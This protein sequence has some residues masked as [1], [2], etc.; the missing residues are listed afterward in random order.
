MAASQMP[1]LLAVRNAIERVIKG[2]QQVSQQPTFTE[3]SDQGVL[4]RGQHADAETLF[5]LSRVELHVVC[6]NAVVYNQNKVVVDKA[7]MSCAFACPS[8]ASNTPPPKVG[9]C[10][11]L[12]FHLL[13]VHEC[14]YCWMPLCL[15]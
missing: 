3:A 2:Q 9:P 13:L 11:L 5:L 1:K 7:N 14:P 6:N 8:I 15:L 10:V 12:A 4:R